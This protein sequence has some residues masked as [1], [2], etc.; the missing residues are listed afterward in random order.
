MAITKL[1]TV[2]IIISSLVYSTGEECDGFMP[3]P[4]LHPFEY[5]E[6]H[7]GVSVR[8]KLYAESEKQAER[9]ARAAFDRFAELEQSMSDYRPS[10]EINQFKSGQSVSKDL[11][12]VIEHAQKISRLSQGAFD[13]TAAPLVQLWRATRESKTLPSPEA[14]AAAKARVGYEHIRLDPK[15]RSVTLAIPNMKLDLGGIAKGYAAD[16]AL[17]ALRRKGVTRALVHAGGDIA[18][19]GPPPGEKGWSIAVP[20]QSMPIQLKNAAISTSGDLNQF[21]EIEGVRYSHIIDSS[22]GLGV[23]NRVVCTVIAPRGI[24]SDPVATAVCAMDGRDTAA[25]TKAF[26]GIKIHVL[27]P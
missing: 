17:I 2:A 7:M 14:L 19:S 16:Q 6:L 8:I 10:S 20:Y 1:A 11:F 15:T 4:T 24:I 22:T 23:T 21:V 27:R 26:R 5:T 3:S 9:A 13:I 12:T 18:V 25:F